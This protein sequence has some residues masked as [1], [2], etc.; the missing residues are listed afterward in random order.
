MKGSPTKFCGTMRKSIFDKVVIHLLMQCFLIQKFSEKKGPPRIFFSSV[1]QKI[2][3]RKSWYPPPSHKIFR[4]ENFSEKWRVLPRI[5]SVLWGNQV[6]TKSWY[7]ILCNFLN[8]E[9]FWNKR[10]PQQNFLVLWD[11]KF[12]R[13]NRDPPLLHKNFR[14]QKVS[15]SQN[16]SFTKSSGTVRQKT[17]DG[18]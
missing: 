6:S 14:Y 8:P 13:Q 1:R 9:I 3:A 5:F 10:I 16:C 7:T 11:K 4:Q 12:P 18:K 2:F 15:E 17:F